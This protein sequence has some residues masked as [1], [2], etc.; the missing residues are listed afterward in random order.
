MENKTTLLWSINGK[1]GSEWKQAN[2]AVGQHGNYRIG[3]RANTDIGS[4]QGHMTI[5]DTEFS[6]CSIKTYK[7]AKR[8]G[9]YRHNA[10]A[11]G[12]PTILRTWYWTPSGVEELC[13]KLALQGGYTVS[14]S[15]Y[16]RS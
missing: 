16:R 2:V 14:N 7:K 8:I 3:I 5:D 10:T 6:G 1:Q 13:E 4:P 15:M 9:C 11:P 12:L